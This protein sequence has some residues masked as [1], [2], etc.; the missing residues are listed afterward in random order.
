MIITMVPVAAELIMLKTPFYGHYEDN[1]ELYKEVM[2]R[3]Q[4]K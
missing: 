2:A 1:D 4:K 3:S